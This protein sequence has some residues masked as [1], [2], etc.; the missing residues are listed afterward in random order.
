MHMKFMQSVIVYQL[1][2]QASQPLSELAG[3]ET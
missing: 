2:M 1:R 3:C